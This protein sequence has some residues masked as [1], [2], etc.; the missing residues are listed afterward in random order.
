MTAKHIY[1]L[2]PDAP[3][4]RD[5][6]MLA[7][8]FKGILPSSVDLRPQSPPIYDQGELG[9]CTANAIGAALDFMH[10]LDN[11]G[12]GFFGP[13]RLFIY[14]N[15]RNMEGTVSEDAGASIRDGIKSVNRDGACKEITWPY[16]VS[17]FAVKPSDAAVLEATSFQA[18]TYQRV[19]ILLPMVKAALAA[20]LPVVC[21]IT[22]YES[23][24]GEDVA[25]TGI[26]PMP[27]TAKEQLLGGHAVCIVGYD[28]ASKTFT[29][30]NSWG[31]SWGDKGHFHL[32]YAF[33]A[34]PRLTSDAWAISKAE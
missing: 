20:G 24:E 26:V 22:V 1:K 15:E 10:K 30:R 18:V 34:N 21:G 32:P 12:A 7:P 27:D 5:R 31:D 17:Q 14:F 13:S 8:P 2:K 29:V 6:V 33:V 11:P 23:F 25:K 28:D 4:F 3:D 19:P 9:S 16:D